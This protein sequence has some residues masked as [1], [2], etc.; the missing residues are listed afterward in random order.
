MIKQSLNHDSNLASRNFNDIK[1]CRVA[2][3]TEL[4]FG[5]NL[6]LFTKLRNGC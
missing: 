5:A 1:G 6:T 3:I 2:C 4:I